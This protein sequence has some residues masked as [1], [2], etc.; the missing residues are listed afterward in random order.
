[1]INSIFF[2]RSSSTE[3]RVG[4]ANEIEGPDAVCELEN[5]EEEEEDEDEEENGSDDF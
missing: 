3:K 1:L 4:A 5:M 2:L